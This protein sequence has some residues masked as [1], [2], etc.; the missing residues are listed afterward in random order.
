MIIICI[1][2]GTWSTHA[3]IILLL[4]LDCAML[5]VVMNMVCLKAYVYFLKL[6]K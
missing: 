1:S 4:S 3:A 2:C 6:Y 5:N